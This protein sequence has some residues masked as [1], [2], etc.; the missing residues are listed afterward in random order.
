M[1]TDAAGRSRFHTGSAC[2]RSADVGA[3]GGSFSLRCAHKVGIMPAY[4]GNSQIGRFIILFLPAD[5]RLSLTQVDRTN[6]FCFYINSFIF[7]AGVALFSPQAAVGGRGR[8]GKQVVYLK[9]Q[10]PS[11][12]VQQ[13]F[14]NG[15]LSRHASSWRRRAQQPLSSL[16]LCKLGERTH[17]NHRNGAKWSADERSWYFKLQ[18]CSLCR[19]SAWLADF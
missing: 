19:L 12:R 2:V 17:C 1:F 3:R 15:I 7:A 10:Q 6:I 16:C 9:R 4:R 13:V 18:G 8:S 14:F 11:D 5:L